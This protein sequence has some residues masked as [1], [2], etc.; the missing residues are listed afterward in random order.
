MRETLDLVLDRRPDGVGLQARDWA[1]MQV[2]RLWSV[3]LF[4]SVTQT[5]E[6]RNVGASLITR[7]DAHDWRIE[8]DIARVGSAAQVLE[9]WRTSASIRGAA[10]FHFLTSVQAEGEGT[11]RI[12]T[13]APYADIRPF[14]DAYDL[15]IGLGSASEAARA[16]ERSAAADLYPITSN[17]EVRVTVDSDGRSMVPDR[18]WTASGLPATS[19]LSAQVSTT[20]LTFVTFA[21]GPRGHLATVDPGLLRGRLAHRLSSAPGCEPLHEPTV[22]ID[23]TWRRAT[24][25]FADFSPNRH[26]ARAICDAADAT[27]GKPRLA[28]RATTYREDPRPRSEPGLFMTIIVPMNS[29][30]TGLQRTLAASP[31]AAVGD[32]D[33][34][35]RLHA[36]LDRD[37]LGRNS[38][39]IT[40]PSVLAEC[41]GIGSVG[42]YI[43][44]R[45]NNHGWKPPVSKMGILPLDELEIA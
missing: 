6:Y 41:S 21:E 24:L 13:R 15:W 10:A 40:S 26:V 18:R 4:E 16:R 7:L 8:V 14:F 27:L 23:S 19:E 28:S 3:P 31:W 39:P 11:M 36:L 37:D 22:A 43:A 20:L 33:R 5:N 29:A 12:T 9:A 45:S 44:G 1:G 35:A 38:K 2:S 17:S 30:G 42:N 25:R 34:R 32:E